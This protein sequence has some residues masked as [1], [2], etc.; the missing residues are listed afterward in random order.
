MKYTEINQ[1]S[2]TV[3]DRSAMEVEYM[4]EK[5]FEL[6]QEKQQVI[7]N[8]ALEVFSQNDYK[9]AVTDDIAAKAGISKGLLFYYFHNKQSLY[10]Y[11]FQYA[12]EFLT[13]EI[14]K[15]Q[16]YELDD[17]FEVLRY[18][19]NMKYGIFRKNPYL[20]RFSE[21]VIMQSDSEAGAEIRNMINEYTKSQYE[22][23]FQHINYDKF[24]EGADFMEIMRMLI[25]MAE[26]YMFD[27]QLKGKIVDLDELM[28]EFEEW[29]TVF[30]K[31][32]YK[33]EFQ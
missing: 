23:F 5:F 28:R 21:K 7:I 29:I 6:T 26:G 22:N 27:L 25:W 4:N 32:A 17:F 33:E 12:K 3:L 15:E 11:L 18:T 2:Q 10:T 20:L 24:R 14:V 31:I 1:Y 19:A 13:K 16:Y 8:A 9:H 30:K